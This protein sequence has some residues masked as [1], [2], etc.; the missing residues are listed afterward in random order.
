M[1]DKAKTELQEQINILQQAIME[2]RHA[3]HN[4]SA[5]YTKG[6]GGL[7]QQVSM[8]VSKG[9][10]AIIKANEILKSE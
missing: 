6:E 9:Q 1:E 4:G 8:W 7:F 2:V 5:W 10:D 3:Q